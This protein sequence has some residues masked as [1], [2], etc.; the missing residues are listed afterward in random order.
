VELQTLVFERY[1]Y[2]IDHIKT[3]YFYTGKEWDKIVSTYDRA[4]RD[5][6]Q[7]HKKDILNLEFCETDLTNKLIFEI[8]PTN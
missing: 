6:K 7:I 8:S 3:H 5:L 4:L 1:R 2:W